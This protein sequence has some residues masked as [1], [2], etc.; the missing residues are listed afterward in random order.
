MSPSATIENRETLVLNK[1]ERLVGPVGSH[2]DESGSTIWWDHGYRDRAGPRGGNESPATRA[3][4]PRRVATSAGNRRTRSPATRLCLG[5]RRL[6]AWHLSTGGT[7]G[8][9]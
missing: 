9:A 7:A 5:V 8:V 6:S 1:C 3:G 2:Y 4:R